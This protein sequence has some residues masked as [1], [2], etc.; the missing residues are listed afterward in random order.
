[1]GYLINEANNPIGGGRFPHEFD[2]A[3]A[4]RRICV[5]G[6]PRHR[7]H[8]FNGGR[9]I[10]IGNEG[11]GSR[12]TRIQTCVAMGKTGDCDEALGNRAGEPIR[13]ELLPFPPPIVETVGDDCRLIQG[14]G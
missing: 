14:S 3:I 8:D 4:V 11:E 6:N 12:A 2:T 10:A 7:M 5:H 13:T 1:M 9:T